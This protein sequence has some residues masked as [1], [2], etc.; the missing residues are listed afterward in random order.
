[1]IEFGFADTTTT[2]GWTERY[3]NEVNA[4]GRVWR[5]VWY[6]ATPASRRIGKTEETSDFA[7][8]QALCNGGIESDRKVVDFTDFFSFAP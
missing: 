3:N 5:S 8:S 6:C 7:C 4:S 1:L 2:D